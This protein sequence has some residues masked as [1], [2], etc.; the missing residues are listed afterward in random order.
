MVVRLHVKLVLVVIVVEVAQQ[1]SGKI[2]HAI[3]IERS[4][5]NENCTS[6]DR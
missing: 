5:S 6:K 3:L 4:M 2:V 1:G